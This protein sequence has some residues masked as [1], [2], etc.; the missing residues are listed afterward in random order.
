MHVLKFILLYCSIICTFN[1]FHLITY[2]CNEYVGLC[3][4]PA[5]RSIIQSL[6]AVLH[7]LCYNILFS[8]ENVIYQ[9]KSLKFVLREDNSV[10]EASQCYDPSESTLTSLLIGENLFP[11]P[12]YSSGAGI[13]SLRLLGR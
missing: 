1:A 3:Y 4:I 8:D 7:F 11:S 5:F 10:V 12:Q 6:H 13:E 2:E 9:L